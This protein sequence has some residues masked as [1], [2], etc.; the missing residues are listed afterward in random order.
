M[1]GPF[2][3]LSPHDRDVLDERAASLAVSEQSE[4]CA[5]FG[6]L[7]VLI[8]DE[9]YGLPVDVVREVVSEYRLT[10]VPCAPGFVLGVV[11]LRGEIVS[12]TDL[13]AV[14]G[15]PAPARLRAAPLVVV[16]SDG[17]T[18]ALAVD[19]VGDIAEVATDAVRPPLPLLDQAHA[20]AVAGSFVIQEGPVALLDAVALL[21]PVGAA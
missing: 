3:T 5:T 10:P 13:A 4:E 14:L 12:V 16:S 8:G 6:V 7:V 19:S 9:R 1:T 21:T 20:D 2:D 17:V 18:T 15:L 11:N